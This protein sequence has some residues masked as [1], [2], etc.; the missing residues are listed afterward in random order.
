MLTMTAPGIAGTGATG[1]GG[2]T[3]S[4]GTTGAGAMVAR[5]DVEASHAGNSSNRTRASIAFGGRPKVL[6]AAHQAVAAQAL[7]L[8]GILYEENNQ[9]YFAEGPAPSV[10][11]G[12]VSG[13]AY[14]QGTPLN[15]QVQAIL[16][17]AGYYLGPVDGIEDWR[18]EQSIEAYQ[19]D[20]HLAVTGQINGGL[21]E[22]MGVQ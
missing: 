12:G 4:Q 9:G 7:I 22:S 10:N 11:G 19:R 21:I 16:R 3:D 17:Q 1:Q 18:T 13:T 2:A 5:P 15:A 8:N 20:H 14:T 6:S